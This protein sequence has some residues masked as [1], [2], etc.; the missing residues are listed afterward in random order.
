MIARVKC[1]PDRPRARVTY[2]AAWEARCEIG[3]EIGRRRVVVHATK[4]P[5]VASSWQC[6]V[7][8]E[9]GEPTH[10]TARLALG[11]QPE[12]HL[13]RHADRPSDQR[14]PCR[15][16]RAV[17]QRERVASAC[18]TEIWIGCGA[19]RQSKVRR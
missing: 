3:C 1:E 2:T 14:C 13:Q 18:D 15:C 12:L 8:R 17:R 5:R 6:A 11:I 19:E 16:V 9:L 7:Q 4:Q 10:K